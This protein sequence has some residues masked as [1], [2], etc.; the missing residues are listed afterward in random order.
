[1][2]KTH[3]MQAEV[4][5]RPARGSYPKWAPCHGG[6]DVEAET[7]KQTILDTKDELTVAGT[8]YY[9]SAKGNDNNDG[10]TPETAWKTVD[11]VIAHRDLLKAGDGVLIERGYVYR[12]PVTIH[13][14]SGV[15]YAAYGEG[16]KPALY[17]SAANYASHTWTLTDDTDC[18]WQLLLDTLEAGIIVFNH[19]VATGMPKYFGIDEL[20]K[21]GDFY[22]D[23][24]NHVLY[25]YLDKGNPSSV[26]EDIEIGTRAT[27]F[28]VPRD[29]ED[30]AVDNLAFKYAGLFAFYAS[31]NV[32]NTRVTNCE[33]GWVGGCRFMKSKVGLGN[34]VSYWQGAVDALVDNC[35][36]YQCYDAGITPQGVNDP[37][38]Y[39]N[40]V[41]RNNLIEYCNY[42]IEIFDRNNET[43]WDGLLIE[44]NILRFAGYGFI[45]AAARPDSRIGVANYVGWSW[46]YDEFPGKGFV[47]HN[48]VFDC[49]AGNLVFW[50]GKTYT[51]GL[52]ISGNSFYQKTNA[53][54]KA[55]HFA[56]NEPQSAANQEELEAAVR[57]FDPHAKV[58]KW[59]D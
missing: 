2:S 15:T 23:L 31:E 4:E 35:W 36:I 45:P 52:T 13:A 34:A 27:I 42:P 26:Y 37:H 53:N 6:A 19:G 29:G 11:A 24:E 14:V 30:V 8:A 58:I 22:H 38:L 59:L 48:N 28:N 10:L 1:M 33:F 51:E 40:V 9:V 55:I 5:I 44:N 25:M 16:E 39:K 49:S 57:L 46:N 7:L 50:Y 32:K 41:F 18:I 56:E 21:N 12:C 20:V 47:M 17:G 43:V 3:I 54:R